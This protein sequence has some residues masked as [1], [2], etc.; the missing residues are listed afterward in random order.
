MRKTIAIFLV[1]CLASLSSALAQDVFIKRSNDGQQKQSAKVIDLFPDKP[2][3]ENKSPPPEAPA[4]LESEPAD[5]APQAKTAFDKDLAEKFY[6]EK[7][8]I[9]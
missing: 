7:G 5:P 6:Q 9:K 2:V 4:P 3:V 8:L 1:A